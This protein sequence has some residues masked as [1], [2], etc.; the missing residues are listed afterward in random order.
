MEQK[1]NAIFRAEKL[2]KNSREKFGYL[3][4]ETISNSIHAAFIRHKRENDSYIPQISIK[5][6]SEDKK[7]SIEIHDNGDGFN[8]TN[9]ECFVSLDSINKDKE[10]LNLH[11]MGQGRLAI[12]FFASSAFFDSTYKGLQGDLERIRFPYPTETKLQGSLFDIIGDYLEKKTEIS[13]TGTILKMDFSSNKHSRYTTFFKKH[14]DEDKIKDWLIQNFFPFFMNMENLDLSVNFDGVKFTISK[15]IIEDGIKNVPF[16]VEFPKN[17]SEK[18]DFKLWL[19]K[20]QSS[21][22]SKIKVTCFARQLMADLDSGSIEYEIDLPEAY[23]WFLTSDYFD[24]RVNQTGDKIETSE[25]DIS[26]IQT[27]MKKALDNHFSAEIN[28]N[29]KET[30][31]NIKSVKENYH[32][33]G[34]FIDEPSLMIS[35]KVL[36]KPDIISQGIDNKGKVE[37][38]YWTN[39]GSMVEDTDKLIN[40]SLHVYVEH[41]SRVLKDFQDLLKKYSENGEN[42][43]EA[44]DKIHELF[45][46][47]GENLQK[48]QNI[49]HLH[50]LWILDDKYTIFSESFKGTSFKPGKS[51]ADICIWFDDPEKI[52]ELLILEL[53]STT[54]AHNAGDKYESMVAQVKRYASEF[55]KNPGKHLN[56]DVDTDKILY[57]AFILARKT[58]IYRELNSNNT[59]GAHRKIPYLESSF[60]FPDE[61]FSVGDSNS[62]PKDIQIRIEMYS[63]EDILSLA[64]NRNT[65][66]FKLLKG[67]FKTESSKE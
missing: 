53:K 3:L 13:D 39:N 24:Q 25:D 55:Y 63:Y 50:N 40:S 56:W 57:V 60:F 54:K 48:S 45:L 2:Y 43:N 67:E 44:E 4:R 6:K 33:I 66:F 37:K 58:D 42:K 51:V 27:A 23:E 38:N 29:R 5:I 49:N 8:K 28:K 15:K 16:S 36:K 20:K 34:V 18:I 7:A 22:K 10:R 19:L 64:Q 31:E 11:P 1:S 46:K 32:S 9:S 17:N 61:R 14:D 52:K 35:N 30:Q 62:A 65:V 47:R 59:S 41:R 21:P 26:A 12:L